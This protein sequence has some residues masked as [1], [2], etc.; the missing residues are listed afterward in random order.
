MSRCAADFAMMY[1][2]SIAGHVQVSADKD[3]VLW[4]EKH[5]GVFK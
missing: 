3:C 4:I 5:E 1:L 2:M